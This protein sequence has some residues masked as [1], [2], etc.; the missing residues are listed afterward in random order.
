MA[1]A[2]VLMA[3]AG[4]AE[5]RRALYVGGVFG[6]G[7]A[8]LEIGG[9]GSLT[10]TAGSPNGT[11]SSNAVA[12]TPD[13]AH[14][15]A[16]NAGKGEIYTYDVNA[17][18]SLQA[19]GGIVLPGPADPDAIAIAPDGR[20]AYVT[21]GEPEAVRI[22]AIEPSG[23][24]LPIDTVTLTGADNV[25]G[26][27][28]TP[29]GS[30]LFVASSNLP[31]RIYGFAVGIDGKLTPQ[32]PAF[33]AA[34]AGTQ[35]LTIRP[36]GNTLYSAAANSTGG[37]QAFALEEGTLLQLKG[38]PYATG[39]EHNGIAASP[40]GKYVYAAREGGP[41][42]SLES[43]AIGEFGTLSPLGTPVA[44]AGETDG[45]AVT[46][47]GRFV[48][49]A[50]DIANGGVSTFA[51]TSGLLALT[52]PTPFPS[53]V[54]LPI[55]DSL[56]ISPNQ[57]PVASFTATQ[58]GRSEAV[59]FD[60]RASTDADSTIARY[61][62]N[63]G[64]GSSLANGGPTPTHTY[65]GLGTYAAS[66]TLTDAEGCS[67]TFVFSGQTASCNGSPV[68]R[69]QRSVPVADPPPRLRLFG[70]K[71][72][73][74][75]G[76]IELRVLCDK[77]CRVTVRGKLALGGKRLKVRTATRKASNLRR[78]KLKL[79]L[80]GKTLRKAKAGLKAGANARAKVVATALDSR[81]QRSTRV[82]RSIRLTLPSR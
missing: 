30:Q 67:T 14:L 51:T 42:G 70:A 43:H 33:T 57:P 78:T 63:F 45:I 74:L 65:P 5:A 52:S 28:I 55:F 22:F 10:A 24:L 2:I 49:S 61:D 11:N 47:D 16:T 80:P 40:D 38:S 1:A 69:T 60:A 39:V 58:E 6:D 48:Y 81:G 27:A 66:V 53:N 36:D 29:D 41:K 18:G 34:T 73:T 32:T 82:L 77:P 17:D 68:A 75:D 8:S 25:S 56:A 35:A 31:A 26:V 76:T 19:T 21:D 59:R 7:I 3:S 62:W 54:K 4:A 71:R 13:G 23:S 44:A 37:I 20:H 64:D 15:F 72:Q 9:N 12:L 50:G 79:S 46:P